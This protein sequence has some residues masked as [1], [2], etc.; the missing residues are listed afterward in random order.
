MEFLITEKQLKK[1][2]NEIKYQKEIDSI[3]DMMNL[4]NLKYE[5][6][7]KDK[8]EILDKADDDTFISKDEYV[9]ILNRILSNYPIGISIEDINEIYP[10]WGKQLIKDGIAYDLKKI[11]NVT[12]I[13]WFNKTNGV[14]KSITTP[15]K[16]FDRIFLKNLY[17]IIKNVNQKINNYDDTF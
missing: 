5:D 3:L 15:L 6:L 16:K 7:P 12:G 14:I 13:F 9:N 17:L 10:T 2:L 4:Y 1:I 8:K 11:N